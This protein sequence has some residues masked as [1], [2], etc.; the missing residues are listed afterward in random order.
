MKIKLFLTQNGLFRLQPVYIIGFCGFTF[1][2]LLSTVTYSQ[3][4]NWGWANQIHGTHVDDIDEVN[5]NTRGE[6]LVSGGFYS[7][8]IQWE[9]SML[10]NPFE[11]YSNG[12]F[13]GKLNT[14]GELQWTNQIFSVPSNYRSDV[15]FRDAELNAFG[16]S[17]ISGHVYRNGIAVDTL[18][19]YTPDDYSSSGFITRFDANGNIVWGHIFEDGCDVDAVV[20]D[21]YGGF[22]IMGNMYWYCDKIDFGDTVIH[23]DSENQAYIAHYNKDNTIDWAKLIQGHVY[24]IRGALT[25]NDELLISGNYQI[26][27]FLDTLTIDDITITCPLSTYYC[28]FWGQLNTEGEV[29]WLHNIAEEDIV[30]YGTY[31]FKEGY[32]QI[33]WFEDP[34]VTIQG[35]TFYEEPGAY[36]SAIMVSFDMSG[37]FLY[38]DAIPLTI[39]G[40][41]YYPFKSPTDN[42]FVTL[43]LRD[44]VDCE[45]EFLYNIDESDDVVVMQIDTEF[46]SL[47][48]YHQELNS[49]A[50]S[51]RLIWDRF[52]NILMIGNFSADTLVFGEDVLTNYQLQ[53]QSD[54]YVA[55]SNRCDTVLSSL[56]M[57]GNLLQAP[58]GVSW[59]WYFNDSLLIQQTTQVVANL[60]TGYYTASATQEDGCVKWTKPVWYENNILKD[61]IFI[62]PNP[63]NGNCIIILPEAISYCQIYDIAG[64]LVYNCVPTEQITLELSHLSSGTYFIKA[65]NSDSVYTTKFIII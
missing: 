62:Y 19:L 2:F 10:I 41:N 34:S 39:G 1:L 29:Q 58:D 59:A 51:P 9:D 55:Y 4:F 21:P 31:L 57:Q 48:C 37:D 44:S 15:Y 33:M 52:G 36:Y 11:N 63:S 17:F 65:G 20:A 28:S 64:Q 12:I 40:E 14:Q 18:I 3:E 26:N 47:A 43:A 56:I 46:N 27:G 60:Q 49:F 6:I 16:E 8:A 22:Y 54:Y 5:T 35:N 42:W 30:F 24:D 25:N 50:N 32:K 38:A 7:T 45:D 53:S 13:L 23:N 61:E